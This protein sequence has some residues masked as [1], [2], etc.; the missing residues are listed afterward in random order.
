MALSDAQLE[1]YS[2]NVIL[3][4]IGVKGQKKLLAG[5]VL[6][7]GA[8]GLGAPAAMYLAAAGVGVLGLADADRVDLSNLQRQIIHATPDVGKP[9][10]ASARETIQAL[11]PDVEV[12]T[13][14][15]LVQADNVLELVAD[16]DFVIDGTDNFPAKFLIN[17]A[18]VLAG[19]PFSHAG[20]IRFKGQ[21][22]T[23]VPGQGACYRCLFVAPPPPDA[24]P[25]CRQAGVV[26]ALAGVLGS[27]QAMEAVKYLTGVGQLLTG[28][29]LTFDALSMDFRTIKVARRPNCAVCGPTPTILRPVDLQPAVCD[30]KAAKTA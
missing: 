21:T 26:G 5:K 29:L 19:K 28:R 10:V 25:T 18:C 12:R 9:K 27:L 23:W 22:T 17:D 24:V 4:E 3:K 16:Y 14:E 20:I 13:L 1:R 2:R 11:N 8:G 15:G 30:L 6:I 7:V